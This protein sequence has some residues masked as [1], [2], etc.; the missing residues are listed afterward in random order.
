[1]E[2]LRDMIASTKKAALKTLNP[3]DLLQKSR[4]L[5]SSGT[6][7]SVFYRRIIALLDV[8]ISRGESGN[9]TIEEAVSIDH[10]VILSCQTGWLHH[11]IDIEGSLQVLEKSY[12]VAEP[13][14]YD[15]ANDRLEVENLREIVE[16]MEEKSFFLSRLVKRL[17]GQLVVGG[18]AAWGANPIPVVNGIK[19]STTSTIDETAAL[20]KLAGDLNEAQ[21]LMDLGAT[22]DSSCIKIHKSPVVIGKGGFGVVIKGHVK[23]QTSL[24]AVAIK[25]P[26]GSTAE[27]DI[28]REAS[29]LKRLNPAP[30]LVH[31]IGTSVVPATAPSLRFKKDGAP[32][33]V[34]IA[35]RPCLIMS[36]DGESLRILIDH[37]C[38][39]EIPPIPFRLRLKLAMDIA[40]AI[41]FLHASHIIHLDIKPANVLIDKFWN[42]R[43]CDF[44]AS[45]T[46]EMAN[47]PGRQ[48]PHTPG[49][50]PPS[51]FKGG[52][53]TYSNDIYALGQLIQDIAGYLDDFP[54][55]IRKLISVCCDEN[56]HVTADEVLLALSDIYANFD[57]WDQVY[58]PSEGISSARNQ[59]FSNYSGDGSDYGG[60][61]G[62]GGSSG[63]GSA[64]GIGGR[65]PT[66][67]PPPR[68][69]KVDL[70]L[71]GPLNL[72]EKKHGDGEDGDDD[73]VSDLVEVD[74]GD[75]PTVVSPAFPRRS[76]PLSLSILQK[77]SVLK[78]AA[79]PITMVTPPTPPI[80]KNLP[81]PHVS[82]YSFLPA[83]LREEDHSFVSSEGGNNEMV[84]RKDSLERKQ[85]KSTSYTR[86]ALSTISPLMADDDASVGDTFN[87]R[88]NLESISAST[89]T[90]ATVTRSAGD[91]QKHGQGQVQPA[92]T[93]SSSAAALPDPTTPSEILNSSNPYQ[94]FS[95]TSFDTLASV[96]ESVTVPA[97]R[98]TEI[99]KRPVQ[100]MIDNND[101]D[102]TP[103]PNMTVTSPFASSGNSAGEVAMLSERSPA[104]SRIRGRDA[105]VPEQTMDGIMMGRGYSV[106]AGNSGNYNPRGDDLR[107]ISPMAGNRDRY[108]R[109]DT[110]N[111]PSP[112]GGGGGS[113]LGS[114]RG[115]NLG[116]NFGYDDPR[117]KSPVAGDR[118][119]DD[120]QVG[121]PAPPPGNRYG[122]ATTG[123]VDNSAVARL[124]RELQMQ[125]EET[126]ARLREEEL[127]RLRLEEELIKLRI[128]VAEKD[129]E[130]SRS[131]TRRDAMDTDGD[132][133]F[134][135]SADQ[136]ELYSTRPGGQEYFTQY[137][138]VTE[139]PRAS[140][141]TGLYVDENQ[142]LEANF[143]NRSMSTGGIGMTRDASRGRQPTGHVQFSEGDNGYGVPGN[144]SSDGRFG[145]FDPRFQDGRP[146]VQNQ[147]MN[148]LAPEIP[149]PREFLQQQQN[150]QQRSPTS[151]TFGQS[152]SGFA[153]PEDPYRGQSLEMQTSLANSTLLS[154][155][156]AMTESRG[157]SLSAT[158]EKY[159]RDS[160]SMSPNQSLQG[161]LSSKTGSLAK[162]DAGIA[163][164][165]VNKPAEGS[166]YKA[167]HTSLFG[168]LFKKGR[169]NSSKTSPQSLSPPS[170]SS[171]QTSSANHS[172][173]AGHL[174]INNGRP[175]LPNVP[176]H[177]PLPQIPV[178]PLFS[179]PSLSPIRSAV[180]HQEQ[181]HDSSIDLQQR[182]T[183]Q[184]LPTS[185][186]VSKHAATVSGNVSLSPVEP[187]K[188]ADEFHQLALAYSSKHH[189]PTHPKNPSLALKYAT[190]AAEHY[191]HPAAQGLL[192]SFYERG[193][194]D[195]VLTP[196]PVEA[197]KFYMAAAKQGDVISENNL[198]YCYRHGV[199]VTRDDREAV[200]WY[201]RAA[202]RG[203]VKAQ[204]NLAMCYEKGVGI[205][206]DL[207]EA[208]RWYERAA[209][210]G[211]SKA[212]ERIDKLKQ[213][214]HNVVG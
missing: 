20:A 147:S 119:Y 151:P 9:L 183:S 155:N 136:A 170:P 38:R 178:E 146:F 212:Q 203:Y 152:Q 188:T 199:G 103:T 131:R 150:N 125:R 185:S 190:E 7:Q 67:A 114:P 19:G 89:T 69:R 84:A 163:T 10:I 169:K 206:K 137:G 11:L 153:G 180:Q 53:I 139:R 106:G 192:G 76:P 36:L 165:Q 186:S 13:R 167:P 42:A 110:S 23:T 164:F 48:T 189:Y 130:R 159:Q 142:D 54:D 149:V 40:S 134:R 175:N 166:L 21:L 68:K 113:G 117:A 116:A 194:S 29:I 24:R 2:A 209:K 6:V 171:P 121:S 100:R 141:A 201:Q 63:V 140:T 97:A 107:V 64:V 33:Q 90:S 12:Q 50:A 81:L 162:Q 129:V 41:S 72:K 52:K 82:E 3:V 94:G 70:V 184:S 73:D 145:S 17:K 80:T 14:G 15:A 118:Y 157:T 213:K 91:T 66:L 51:F 132:D 181:Q 28:I 43:L 126:D 78:V 65:S 144:M 77:G 174:T 210:S 197:V 5:L 111:L 202:F 75:G 102:D 211:D 196:N 1:M 56:L 85:S 160:F 58:K 156:M 120:R 135:R 208:I 109:D 44:G 71:P 148:A 4:D 95:S 177:H 205:D 195:G 25:I 45:C 55:V 187:P 37:M 182:Q 79:N 172:G 34:E 98:V 193:L 108:S 138:D 101:D 123:F 18:D 127:R 161:S 39:R 154:P 92:S 31:L 32:L 46:V 168:D 96:S 158:S 86:S 122:M 176:K 83:S 99:Y 22:V 93:P 27:T 124:A 59:K 74:D 105:G 214:V 173:T 128:T 16:S 112:A 26:E 62:S 57:E 35:S 104:D 30:H 49:Y 200:R 191:K 47:T 8:A 204:Y 60:G 88:A 143:R 207:E 115:S 198:G 133:G 61:G 87:S 179:V